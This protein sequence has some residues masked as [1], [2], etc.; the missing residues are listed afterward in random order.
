[1]AADVFHT[2]ADQS[3]SQGKLDATELYG[4]ALE[5]YMKTLGED[6]SMVAATYC[7]IGNVLY[8]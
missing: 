7:Q 6:H 4:K 3:Q 1:L 8:G 2:M 5:I